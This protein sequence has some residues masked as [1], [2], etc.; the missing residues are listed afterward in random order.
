MTEVRKGRR[1]LVLIALVF[2]SPIIIASVL[3]LSGW[4]P[5]GR[6]NYGELLDPPL[7][8][9]QPAS[10]TSGAVLDWTTPKWHWTLV[11]RVPNACRQACLERLDQVGNLRISLGR[12]AEKLRIAVDHAP[13]PESVLGRAAGVYTLAAVP[14]ELSE[15]LA[16]P[17][18]DLALALVDPAGY[19]MLRFPEH[20]DLRLVRKDLGRLIR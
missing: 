13:P 14:T 17:N 16:E 19:L 11:V 18:E 5:E 10:L 8:L 9:Q 4:L 3:A 7:R 6:R 12:H 20:A 1:M 2:A 15:R